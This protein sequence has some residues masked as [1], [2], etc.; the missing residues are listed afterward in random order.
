M[1]AG[2]ITCTESKVAAAGGLNEFGYLPVNAIG[3]AR[4]TMSRRILSVQPRTSLMRGSDRDS[5]RMSSVSP[6]IARVGAGSVA[7]KSL[8]AGEVQPEITFT[9]AE[10][11][12]LMNSSKGVDTTQRVDFLRDSRASRIRLYQSSN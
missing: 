5:D 9:M 8:V 4:N 12:V 3:D 10:S 7:P 1:T 6:D 2:Q 11:A